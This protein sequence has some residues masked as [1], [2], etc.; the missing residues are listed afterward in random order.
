MTGSHVLLPGEFVFFIGYKVYMKKF[1]LFFLFVL[2]TLQAQEFFVSSAGND[3]F[4]GT[5][6]KPFRTIRKGV[7]S[8]KPGDTLT[9]MPGRYRE[10]V[11]W[12]FDGS[13]SQTTVVRA[14]IP[15]TVLIHGDREVTGF[16]A[17]PGKKNC[18]VLSLEN[19]PEGVNE[20]DTFNMYVKDDSMLKTPHPLYKSYF[21]DSKEKKLYIATSDGSAPEKHV[22]TVSEIPNS[23]F[24]LLPKGKKMVQNVVI[25]G[26]CARGFST[27]KHVAHSSTW[28]IELIRAER[29]IIRNCSTYVNEGGITVF[30]SKH[31]RI[32]NCHAYGNGTAKHV[33]AGNIAGFQC[34]DCVIDNCVSWKSVTGAARFYSTNKRNVISNT[35][36]LSDSRGS[37]RI[38][39]DDGSNRMIQCFAYALVGCRNSAH[40][41]YSSNDYDPTGKG[42]PTSLVVK[43]HPVFYGNDFAD[44]WNFDLRLQKNSSLKRGFAGENVFFVS[45]DGK[46]VND[47]RSVKT[48]WKTLKNTPDGATVYF[49]PG[50]YSG[51]FLLES[52]NVTLAGRGQH[53]PALIRGGVT[54]LRITGK[55]T[56][57]K[58]LHFSGQQ[59]C[60]VAFSGGELV[61]EGVVFNKQKSAVSVSGK[62]RLQITHCFFSP[63]TAAVV[64][65][66]KYSGIFAH[67][68]S[69][70]PAPRGLLCAS[71]TKPGAEGI[72]LDGRPFGPYFFF[73]EQQQ[74]KTDHLTAYTPSPST[75]EILWY[76]G[77]A[78]TRPYVYLTGP[79]GVVQRKSSY[80]MDS[81]FHAVSFSGLKPGCEYRFFAGVTPKLCYNLGG[82]RYLPKK[83]DPGKLRGVRS[84]NMTF[85]TPA[86]E[87]PAK[88]WHVATTGN[89]QNDGSAGAPFCTISRGLLATAPGDTLLVHSGIYTES[90]QV[91]FSGTPEKPITIKAAPHAQVWLEGNS[92]RFC[93]GFVLF[94]KSNVHIDGFSFK[95]YG[96]A[97]PNSSGTVVLIGSSGI[98]ISRCF[99]DGRGRG[100]AAPLLTARYSQKISV[101]NCVTMTS[102]SAVTLVES[103]NVEIVNNVFRKPSI[104]ALAVINSDDAKKVLFANNII[105][106]SIRAKTPVAILMTRRRACLIERNNLYF[107][108]FPRHLRKIV[109]TEFP[110]KRMYTLDEYYKAVGVSGKSL[111]QDPGIKVLST[112]LCWKDEAQ[113]QRDLKKPMAF[114]RNN[115]IVEDARNPRNTSQF[116]QWNFADFFNPELFRKHG[117]GLNNALFKDL[118]VKAP[119]G[120]DQR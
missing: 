1:S 109:E 69:G 2:F 40:S 112:Q 6:E 32:E 13:P 36:S 30:G 64:S 68:I 81:S 88:T 72:S 78:V 66:G 99:N 38:K 114:H 9:V 73:Y 14:L 110:E 7:D 12:R 74:G 44:P 51:P 119:A 71:N 50:N 58:R 90:V 42:G 117:I 86:K 31:C 115:N 87:R 113:R 46:D 61:L 24:T 48:P 111:F 27:R 97:F 84:Q 85:R 10:S 80:T 76:T 82:M 37:L 8:L 93:R 120:F 34:E 79:G 15:G 55:N 29:C 20:C 116:V 70:A 59:A 92:R 57:L 53:G 107:M 60:A 26:L 5:K 63:D 77:S 96:T 118:H 22:I 65:G 91:P 103:S 11:L 35:V 39:P 47:G 25:D 67:N 19:T 4:A 83:F 28:G 52:S 33:S 21:Y 102:M 49:L 94:G 62:S 101:T 16:K 45:P 89:D 23:G 43:K 75:A 100:Y 17:V 104:W 41:V 95:N 3:S 108:R 98:R 105:T 18:Y 54:G 106:D 56:T